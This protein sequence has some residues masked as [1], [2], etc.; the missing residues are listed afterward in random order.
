MNWSIAGKQAKVDE[1]GRFALIAV[2]AAGLGDLSEA[3]LFNP[4]FGSQALAIG[5]RTD[6]LNLHETARSRFVL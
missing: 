4:N 3:R 1:V 6:E 2:P 5:N